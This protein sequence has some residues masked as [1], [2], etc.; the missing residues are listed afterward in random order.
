LIAEII[1][2]WLHRH[3]L[4]DCKIVYVTDDKTPFTE[5]ITSPIEGYTIEEDR[6]CDAVERYTRFAIRIPPVIRK[7]QGFCSHHLLFLLGSGVSSELYDFIYGCYLPI[8]GSLILS[9]NN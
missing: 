7:A 2:D 1:P 8:E 9:A 5:I 3:R 4:T 6:V